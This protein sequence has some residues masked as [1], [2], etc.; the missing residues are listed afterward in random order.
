MMPDFYSYDMDMRSD[1][2]GYDRMDLHD[3]DVF[4]AESCGPAIFD[5]P[6]PA[7]EKPKKTFTGRVRSFIRRLKE[8]KKEEDRQ[9]DIRRKLR[10]D[11]GHGFCEWLGDAMSHA[12]VFP[13]WLL[14]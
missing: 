2:Y 7:A 8:I 9:E 11:D 3:G 14:H 10:G 4:L 13:T 12:Y 1:F 5:R 6:E